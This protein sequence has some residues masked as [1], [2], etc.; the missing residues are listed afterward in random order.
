MLMLAMLAVSFAMQAQTKFHD[1]ELNEA[2]GP[3]KKLV[4]NVMGMDQVISFGQDGKMQREGLADAQYDADGYLKSA[5]MS[6]QGQEITVTYKWE[7]GK[8]VSQTMNVM[9]QQME[10]K[11]TYNEQGAPEAEIINMGG[12]EMKSPYTDYKYDSHGNWISRTASMMGQTMTQTRT[13]EY[14]E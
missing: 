11:R 13:I 10:V 2:K 12:Q 6:M 8:V 5:K 9:G 4:V 1:V 14:F 7:G 3:V